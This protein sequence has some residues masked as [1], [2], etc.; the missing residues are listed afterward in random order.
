MKKKILFISHDASR[1][2]APIV[3]LNFIRWFKQNSDIPFL[4]ILV[5][6]DELTEAF[7][8]LAPAILYSPDKKPNYW[9]RGM[10]FLYTIF[11]ARHLFE[12]RYLVIRQSWLKRQLRNSDIGLIY[13]NTASNSWILKQ[14]DW[15]SCPVISHIHELEFIIQQNGN[16]NFN[17]LK[18]N[19]DLFIAC[20]KA[21]KKNLMD[22]HGVSDAMVHVIH[23]F[24]PFPVKINIDKKIHSNRIIQELN[25]TDD[26]FIVGASGYIEWRKGSDLFVQL[27][28]LVIHKYSKPLCFVWLGGY[29]NSKQHL[30][31]L[32]DI[33]K[34][35]L[36]GKVH[37]ITSKPDPL[38]YFECMDVFVLPSREDPFPLVCLE[39]ASLGKPVICFD[40]AGGMPEFVENDSGFIVPYLDIDQMA[41]RIIELYDSPDLLHEMGKNA[42]KKVRERHL[43]EENASKITNLINRM[44]FQ[45]NND[46]N[47]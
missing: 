37:V 34:L 27:A 42:A 33:D 40:N 38:D 23:E 44:M 41:K 5:K 39:A 16:E 1:T 30:E 19:T 15:L 9:I 47:S 28:E 20:S 43:I 2:G 29:Q 32:F 17:Y 21:V 7:T 25:L 6:G 11:N 4:I 12:K 35:D 13:S 46:L 36:K 45:G 26:A 31:L 24:I 10:K 22:N 8:K 18:N 3:L 14:L